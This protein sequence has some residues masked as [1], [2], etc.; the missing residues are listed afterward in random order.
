MSK[1]LIGAN[2]Q[3]TG[4]SDLLRVPPPP[5]SFEEHSTFPPMTLVPTC[6]HG[7]RDERSGHVFLPRSIVNN[8]VPSFSAI[9]S[10][11]ESGRLSSACLFDLPSS[12][13]PSIS[14][15]CLE[16]FFS[17]LVTSCDGP[18]KKP[19]VLHFFFRPCSFLL[20]AAVVQLGPPAHA[21]TRSR[22]SLTFCPL[23]LILT[24]CAQK[25][26]YRF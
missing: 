9:L 24:T 18:W 11:C 13:L 3:K 19:L 15:V 4:P 20:L 16:F 22:C 21:L 17:C 5:L 10:E 12:I 2:R 26:T 1:D 14:R 7:R 8:I 6:L 25:N 23:L